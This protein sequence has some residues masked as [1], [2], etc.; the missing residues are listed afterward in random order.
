MND[1]D[2]A[3]Y[4]LDPSA[5]DAAEWRELVELATDAGATDGEIRDA[6]AGRRLHALPV[7]LG[8]IGGG[9]RIT[10]AEAGARVGLDPE[11]SRQ[12]W[13]ALGLADD[14]NTPCTD[15]DVP[16]FAYYRWALERLGPAEALEGARAMGV[17]LSQLADS[18]IAQMRAAIEA[19]V[20]AGGAGDVDV[21]HLLLG[22]LDVMPVL[23][24]AVLVA[25]RQHV[26]GA[27]RRYSLWGIPPSEASTT[28]CVV[29]F[30]DV[31]GSTALGERLGAA[32]L[33]ARVRA[34]EG[35][36][37]EI[38]AGPD[39]RLV[40][41]IGDEAMFVTGTAIDA[42]TLASALV[43]DPRLPELR[44]GLAAGEVVTRGGDL[45]GPVVNL[46]ARLVALAT[47]GSIVA[48]AQVVAQL[49]TDGAIRIEA[50]GPR[51]LAGF[52]IPVD[53]FEVGMYPRS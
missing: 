32:E 20:R 46:A 44:I 45:Y 9:Q 42:V 2:L 21:A 26:Y 34:F 8:L 7:Q 18:E 50:L 15:R 16:L 28:E 22:L 39:T 35:R 53:V 1:E 11:F 40:K 27:G 47:P 10:V 12:L 33:D 49:P 30:A 14:G 24:D 43:Q 23:Q 48:D 4:G 37:A 31:V 17:S 52:E 13:S 29:G 41:L 3:T 36:V 51:E 19:P 6:I 25:H 5:P 38:A